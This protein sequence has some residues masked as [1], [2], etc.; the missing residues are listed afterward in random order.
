MALQHAARGPTLLIFEDI[1]WFDEDTIEIVQALLHHDSG[2]LLIVVN[3][4]QLPA[5]IEGGQTYSLG[6]LSD[7]E[8][9]TLIRALHAIAPDNPQVSQL[10]L[11]IVRGDRDAGGM[12]TSCHEFAIYHISECDLPDDDINNALL[13]ALRDSPAAAE[14]AARATAETAS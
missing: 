5:E 11:K 1:H 12:N 9:D 14:A 2:R 4:R 8:A 7:D 13:A 6:P 3:G 10:M